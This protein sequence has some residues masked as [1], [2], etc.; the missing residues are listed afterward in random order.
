M[1]SLNALREWVRKMSWADVRYG[2]LGTLLILTALGCALISSAA[3]RQGNWGTAAVLA[4]L[5]LVLAAAIS[6]TVVPRLFKQA[7]REWLTLS[8]HVTREG[9]SYCG[10]LLILGLAAINTGNN[11]I[12][13][14]FSAALAILL[15]SAVL[16]YLNLTGLTATL[17]LPDALYALQDS[18]AIVNLRNNKRWL[19]SMS[20][21][22]ESRFFSS[23]RSTASGPCAGRSYLLFLPA[24]A[25]S[26][27]QLPQCC[28]GLR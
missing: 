5:S 9:W 10:I 2:L 11:L 4:A 24:N 23:R 6:L 13:I 1:F 3:S 7:R 20:L 27:E 28:C 21:S 18:L 12:Y 25:Q 22:L 16:S 17:A 8:I 14:I 15:V 26:V 19:P